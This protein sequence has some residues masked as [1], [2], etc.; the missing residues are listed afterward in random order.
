MTAVVRG[1]TGEPVILLS[2]DAYQQVPRTTLTDMIKAAA[3]VLSAAELEAVDHAV[4]RLG[5]GLL[6][7]FEVCVEGHV[8][9]VYRLTVS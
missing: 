5:A 2:G 3:S 8:L 4:H 7:D 9:N 1:S 6:P